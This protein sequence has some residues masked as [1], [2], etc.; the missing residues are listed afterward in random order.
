MSVGGN[1][2]IQ[3]ALTGRAQVVGGLKQVGGQVGALAKETAVYN[4]QVSEGHRRTWL[5]NQALFTMRRFAYAGTLALTA[6][7]AIATKTGLAFNISMEQNRIA[8]G[9]FLGGTKEAN[10]ELAYLYELAARTPF[11]FQQ[12]V[13]AERR[14]LAFGFSV[15]EARNAL[16]TIGD[17]AA[18]LGGDPADNIERL[19]LVLGQVRATGRVLGQ[20]MLQLQQLGINT[21]QIFREELGLTREDLKQGV[22]EL[23]I[24][25]EVAIPALLRGMQKQFKGM[26][27]QQS[28]T[29]GGMLSTL[30]DYT[31]Q[32]LGA[33]T[34]PIFLDLR[35]RIVPGLIDLNKEMSSAAKSGATWADMMEIVD[36]H[37]G[38]HGALAR[39]WRILANIGSSLAEIFNN[40][41]KPALIFVSA[42][43]AVTLLPALEALSR[44]LLFVA[45]HSTILAPLIVYLTMSFLIYKTAVMISVLWTMRQGLAWKLAILSGMKFGG[46]IRWMTIWI[47]RGIVAL[48]GWAFATVLARSSL[49]T[50]TGR[51]LLHN[52]IMARFIRVM[53]LASA[54]TRAWAASLWVVRTAIFNIPVIGWILAIIA[55]IIVLE[56][57]FHIIQR[58]IENLWNLLIRFRSWI[59]GN[60]ISWD[61]FLPGSG[62]F[63][64]LKFIPGF[65]GMG[66]AY[67]GIKRIPGLAGGG[68]VTSGGVFAVGERGP[69][70]AMLPTGSAVS[71]MGENAVPLSGEGMNIDITLRNIMEMDGDVLEEKLSVIRL[72]KKARS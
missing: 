56:V 18:G 11:E 63:D 62:F 54:A 38:A 6:L 39:T 16:S 14:F 24:P 37:I 71:P 17:V 10:S 21:N 68:H 20:D 67:E 30:H 25:S 26:A 45:D 60:K 2:R 15:D 12:V 53:F 29:L 7:G 51:V 19:V 43:L 4:A 22:G 65:Q 64:K 61:D 9:H 41:V 55:A 57:K 32:L 46:G 13:N 33:L 31:A 69:E 3:M 50:F 72:N 66:L 36:R 40:A 70:L 8:M 23:Q 48:R 28:K 49:G 35:N 44:V 27:E 42:I 1:A 52:S 5:M 47:Y 59:L 58:S 34:M